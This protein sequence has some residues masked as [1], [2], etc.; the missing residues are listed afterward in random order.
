M[1][2]IKQYRV[3]ALPAEASRTLE[4]LYYV[5]ASAADRCRVYLVGETVG[6][7]REIGAPS[8]PDLSGYYL[9]TESDALLDD[10]VSKIGD[11]VVSGNLT[12]G[13]GTQDSDP[14][15]T[16]TTK[17]YVVNKAK[18][19]YSSASNT[20]VPSA[21]I[22]AY[23]ESKNGLVTNGSGF[24]KSNYN[25]S[26]GGK[27]T[28][29]GADVV[30]LGQPGCFVFTGPRYTANIVSTEIIPVNPF[31]FY[32]C[33]MSA[34]GSD[35]GRCYGYISCFDIDSKGIGPY[36]TMR[37]NQPNAAGGLKLTLTQD[38]VDGDTVMH[39]D[40]LSGVA[41]DGGRAYRR[42]LVKDG[43]TNS[44]GDTYE[45]YSR[46]TSVYHA[47]W[48]SYS[49]ID[50]VNNTITLSA[51]VDSSTYYL[52]GVV[53]DQYWQGDSGGSYKY[54]FMVGVPMV[55]GG[56]WVSR[57]TNTTGMDSDGSW[58]V[59]K[60]AEGTAFVKVGVLLGWGGSP[61]VDA[62]Y[63]FTGFAMEKII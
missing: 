33:S 45:F 39:F 35:S 19:V 14:N 63:K 11:G 8:D 22:R 38:V 47:N 46:L 5:K 44:H 32:K 56:P 6:D 61:T 50:V 26:G 12:V 20:F 55:A 1:G 7:V 62:T 41:D 36:H 9:K 29:S 13:V 60:F 25:W 54:V 49:D 30:P 16:L 53:G 31:A 21:E 28:Y 34:K 17:N 48:D 18:G 24:L 2:K 10:K 37:S 42:R 4:S 51:P 3:N 52:R 40:D 23:F 58:I 15:L 59:S 57:T 43:Y 27:L